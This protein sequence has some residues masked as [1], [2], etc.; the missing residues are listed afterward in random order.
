MSDQDVPYPTLADGVPAAANVCPA[1]G[2]DYLGTSL[3]SVSIPEFSRRVHFLEI[4]QL[5]GAEAVRLLSR[6]QSTQVLGD[7]TI[8]VEREALHAETSP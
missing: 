3:V 1:V 2:V 4:H 5:L 6:M 7:V 8:V